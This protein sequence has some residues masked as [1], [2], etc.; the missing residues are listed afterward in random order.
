MKKQALTAIEIE[1]LV[2]STMTAPVERCEPDSLDSEGYPSKRETR[3]R[4]ALHRLIESF[5]LAACSMAGI[6]GGA[7]LDPPDDVA[8]ADSPPPADRERRD[9]D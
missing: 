6:Y 8:R 9:H 2:Q 1:A 7:W 5:A 3:R 4:A